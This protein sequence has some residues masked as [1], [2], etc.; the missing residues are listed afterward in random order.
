MLQVW[1]SK[2]FG[3]FQQHSVYRSS[4][5]AQIVK[6][7]SAMQETKVQSLGWDTLQKGMLTHSTVLAWRIPWTQEP[8]G[9]QPMGSQRVRHDWATHTHTHTINHESSQSDVLNAAWT[10]RI[11]TTIFLHVYPSTLLAAMGFCQVD[12]LEMGQGAVTM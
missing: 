12:V 7:L 5:V 9:L 10:L 3:K 4:L 2:L 6:N 8:G 11:L 1:V